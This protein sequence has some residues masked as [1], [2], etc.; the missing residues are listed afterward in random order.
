MAKII[1]GTSTL[2]VTVQVFRFIV[3]SWSPCAP[4]IYGKLFDLIHACLCGDS[5]VPVARPKYLQNIQ[6]S[7]VRNALACDAGGLLSNLEPLHCKPEQLQKSLTEIYLFD[8][9]YA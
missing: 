8:I 3:H 6:F 9:R 7:P 1:F 2:S 5:Q 4:H